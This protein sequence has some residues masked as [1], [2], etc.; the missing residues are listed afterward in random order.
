M[1]ILA[2]VIGLRSVA[3]FTLIAFVPLWAVSQGDTEAEGN[4]LLSLMLLAGAVGTLLLGPIA[5]R[6]GIRRTLL[7]AQALLT[8]LI[9]VFV[10]AGRDRRRR[11]AGRRRHLRRRHVRA[12]DGAGPDVSRR[13]M[14]ASPRGSRS[15]SRWVSAGSRPSRWVRS[16]TPS[17]SKTALICSALAP[18]LGVVL[19]LFLPAPKRPTAVATAQPAPYPLLD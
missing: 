16:P 13:G 8:P 17:I 14:S 18:L 2:A 10:L 4:R 6:F 19:C 11:R 9:L 15:G 5:D 3:W 7:V 12:H 1:L